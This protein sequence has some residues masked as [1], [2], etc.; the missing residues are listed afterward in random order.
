MIPRPT[1]R[2]VME[3][4]G[5]VCMLQLPGCAQEAT[6]PDHRANR[7]HGGSK[8]LNSPQCLV[9]SCGSCNGRKESA[10]GAELAELIRRGVRVLRMARNE[11]TAQRCLE[12]PVEY[13]DG[14]RWW[15]TPWG[16]QDH[17]ERPF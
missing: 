13:P 8:A 3:R 6:V 5:H 17:E 16:R 14:S 12:V 7:G 9:A 2:A 11:Q 4:D 1:T 10:T 15:L